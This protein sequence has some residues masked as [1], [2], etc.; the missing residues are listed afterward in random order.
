MGSEMCIRDSIGGLIAIDFMRM[1]KSKNKTSVLSALRRAFADNPRGP[2]IGDFSAFGLVDVVCRREGKSLGE[3][4]LSN[5]NV[6][7]VETVAIDILTSLNRRGG[8]SA[9]VR[10][11]K[12]VNDVLHG[13]LAGTVKDLEDRLGFA[14]DIETLDA[15]DAQHYEIVD[16][17]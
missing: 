7:S 12:D 1:K 9:H 8:T 14:I 15:T 2:R 16:Y 10:V 5:Q 6:K 3:H 13:A 4:Y 17:T 11:S